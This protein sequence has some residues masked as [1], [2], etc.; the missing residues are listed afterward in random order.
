MLVCAATAQESVGELKKAI[1]MAYYGTLDTAARQASYDA[2][3]MRVKTA[4]PDREV[5]EACTSRS[6]AGSL[7]E[8]DGQPHPLLQEAMEQLLAD[9]YNS[10][11]VVTTEMIEGKAARL[12]QQR[13]EQLRPRFFEIK[14]TTPLLYSADDCRR[15]LQVVVDSLQVQPDEQAVLVGHGKNGA[16]DDVFC[17]VDYILQHEGHANCHVGTVEGYPGLDNIKEILSQSGTAR[18]VL[19][20]LM[21]TGG[22]HAKRYVAK[23]WREALEQQGYTVR[24]SSRGVLEY[25]GIRQLIVEKIRQADQRP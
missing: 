15:V 22:G 3:T 24:C 10:V 6:L 23:K 16:Y 7:S 25:E 5:R 13:L 8:Q 14:Q 17:L 4:F 21:V 9:G 18:V 19:A 12:M 1:L 2:L 20:P 11:I